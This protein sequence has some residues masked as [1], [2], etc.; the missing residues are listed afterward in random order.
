MSKFQTKL[1]ISPRFQSKFNFEIE[2]IVIP[3]LQKTLPNKAFNIPSIELNKYILADPN[4]NMVGRIDIIIGS[5]L[6]PEVIMKKINEMILQETSLGWKHN[7]VTDL[8]RFWEIEEDAED[9]SMENQQQ[10]LK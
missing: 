5:D 3:K 8:E 9:V 10:L 7:D 2:A 4:F 6:I 1:N